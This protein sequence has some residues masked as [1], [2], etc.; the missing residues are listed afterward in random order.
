MAPKAFLR[1]SVIFAGNG[2]YK[3]LIYNNNRAALSLL[4]GVNAIDV[5]VKAA[6]VRLAQNRLA[7]KSS[8]RPGADAPK[9]AAIRLT[10]VE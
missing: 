9:K 4:N 2:R 6:Q 8:T 7:R 5:N 3:L 10:P 1:D